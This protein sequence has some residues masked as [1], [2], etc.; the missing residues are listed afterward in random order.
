MGIL[1]QLENINIERG[2]IFSDFKRLQDKDVL[3]FANAMAGESGEFCNMIKKYI[4]GDE[5]DRDG[6]TKITPYHICKE[7]ADMI[8]YAEFICS[9]YGLSLSEL[10]K[11]KFNEISIAKGIDVFIK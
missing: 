10:I 3:Y 7:L 6:K 5:F 9:I 11:N 2:K 8:I 4:R 1:E